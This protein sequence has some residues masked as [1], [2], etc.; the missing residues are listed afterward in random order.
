ML[1]IDKIFTI[2]KINSIKNSD[3][4]IEKSIELKTR[5]LLKF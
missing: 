5:K 1:I 2:N 3:E 4:L